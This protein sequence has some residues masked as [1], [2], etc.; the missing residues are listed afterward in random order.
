MTNSEL[1][2]LHTETIEAAK[3][4]RTLTNISARAAVLFTTGGYRADH[5]ACGLYHVHGPHGQHYMTCCDMVM[6]FYCDC[7][8]FAEYNTC[9]HLQAI[10]LLHQDEADAAR[11]DREHEQAEE[12]RAFLESRREL[13]IH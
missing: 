8:A 6:G 10:D 5:F 11:L 2:A 9:K 3:M 13:A 7:P 12:G 1:T 4:A